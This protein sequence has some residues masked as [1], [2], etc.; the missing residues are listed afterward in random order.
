MA[1]A[2][3]DD[4]GPRTL[5]TV[6]NQAFPQEIHTVALFWGSIC[7]TFANIAER[8]GGYNAYVRNVLDK[9]NVD[10]GGGGG[11]HTPAS[12]SNMGFREFYS[13]L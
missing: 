1:T 13:P 3:L 2:L 12:G 10:I 5:E 6:L 8:T 11:D 9:T 4:E 7:C